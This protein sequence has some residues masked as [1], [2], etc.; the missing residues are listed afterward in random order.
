MS[1]DAKNKDRERAS[2]L[3]YLRSSRFALIGYPSNG[4]MPSLATA[5]RDSRKNLRMI[6]EQRPMPSVSQ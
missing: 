3:A 2:R 6:D 5:R 1:A 4:P